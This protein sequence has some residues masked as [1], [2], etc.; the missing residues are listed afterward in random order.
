MAKILFVCHANKQ[1]SPTAE[2]VFREMA[3][4]K[5]IEVKVESAGIDVEEDSEENQL[6]E[7]LVESSDKIFVMED[8]MK[9]AI[10]RDYKANPKK[11]SSLDIPD[12]YH[13]NDPQLIKI[14]REKLGPYLLRIK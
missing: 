8:R 1:R 7:F 14:L 2:S 11:I 6:S 12:I 4:E 13:K 9:E 3:K 10:V 5:G